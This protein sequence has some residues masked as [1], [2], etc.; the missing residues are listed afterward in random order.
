MGFR[1]FGA[2]GFQVRCKGSSGLPQ[3]C[4]GGFSETHTFSMS[5]LSACLRILLCVFILCV[6]KRLVWGDATRPTRDKIPTLIL[7]ELPTCGKKA[8]TL[9]SHLTPRLVT[10]TLR[11]YSPSR[12]MKSEPEPTK[13][14]VPNCCVNIGAF[15]KVAIGNLLRRLHE[16]VGV[17]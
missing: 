13:P 15:K 9:T 5:R 17:V 8:H 10:M 3:G 1:I 7:F 14:K 6:S 16:F 12:C 2:L 4:G 11:L